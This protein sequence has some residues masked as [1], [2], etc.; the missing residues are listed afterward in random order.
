[1]ATDA[2]GTRLSPLRLQEALR[3]MR[4]DDLSAHALAQAHLARI[5]A[6][7]AAVQAWAH[8]DPLRALARAERCDAVAPDRRGPLHGIGV[9]VKDII[10]TTSMPTEMGS[11][12]YAGHHPPFDA[13]CVARLARAGGYVL[14]K[15]VT[16]EFAY[17]HPG[18]TANPWN[19]RHTPGGSS[20]G[21]AAAVAAGQVLG[22]IGSQTNGSVIRPAAYCGVV[23]F[24]PTKDTIPLDGVHVFSATLDQIGTFAHD[25]AG[26]AL[27]ASALADPGRIAA[28]VQPRT[29]RPRV[30]Y[31]ARY[32]W[33]TIDRNAAEMLDAAVARLTA[34][35]ADIENIEL[36]AGWHDAKLVHHTIM[37]RE[38]AAA[39]GE[40]Q[41][42]ERQRMSY[43]LNA[44]LDEGAAISRADYENALRRR[45]EAITDIAQWLLGF[46][47][48]ISPPATGAAPE[49]LDATGDPGC[50]TLWSL[51]GFP[52]IT[53]PIGHAQNGL[54]LGMQIVAPPDADDRLLGVAAWCEARLPFTGLA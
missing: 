16:T 24:K 23:G 19:P 1:M 52:A 3:A 10:A 31:V 30:A 54:P 47:A 35:G 21:S 4:A 6:T 18:K 51:L 7:D 37:M 36:P 8:L 5:P 13:E 32:P 11:P 26:A 9:G 25:V 44:A 53:T 48:L 42:R 45:A 50:C 27:L 20:S 49:G 15:T 46:D 38:G 43:K 39:L 17:F 29:R 28:T 22:A 41:R 34:Q 40:L 33:T 2:D 12:I 14:G